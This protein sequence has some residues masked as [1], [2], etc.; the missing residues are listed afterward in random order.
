[1]RRYMNWALVLSLVLIAGGANRPE[2]TER[3][4]AAGATSSVEDLMALL[5]ALDMVAV[6]D[7]PR[8]MRELLPR[9]KT[10]DIGGISKL[11]KEIEEFTRMAG[12]DA[13][14][15]NAAVAGVK[16]EGL[17]A[18]GGA[19]VMEGIDI[20]P[21][22][23]ETAV[24]AEHW[25]F[26]KI[27]QPGSSLYRVARIKQSEAGSQSG[28]QKSEEV[29]F[30]LLGPQRAVAGDLAT[31]KDVARAQAARSAE[32][33]A[34][35]RAALKETRSSGLIRFALCLPEGLRQMLDSQGELFQQLAA[36]KVIL[37]TLD[38]SGDQSAQLDARLRT[39]SKE[40]AAQLAT[41]LKS[42]VTLGK[43]FL[44]GD[45]NAKT[46]IIGQLL[47]QVQI[48]PQA[49]D[50]SLTLLMPKALLDQWAKKN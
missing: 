43:S 50:V 15:I 34:T 24:T 11:A 36:V 10:I 35:Q 29:Y 21:K 20:D 3:R 23:V 1:M 42:L 44:G 49:G 12:I 27:D 2:G 16:I 38:M 37:G 32:T 46:Q 45:Q 7:M 8:A 6:I 26:Q 17:S 30:A 25:E 47:D 14:K 39:N 28:E 31:V 18:K 48:A 41:G 4:A 19:L 22:R 9:L 40:E 33:N 5:P 13:T